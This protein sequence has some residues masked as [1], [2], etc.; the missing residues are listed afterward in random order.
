M[1]VLLV[2][3]EELI[4]E[5]MNNSNTFQ[6]DLDLENQKIDFSTSIKLI[7]VG[8]FLLIVFCAFFLIRGWF[9]LGFSVLTALFA[10]AIFNFLKR[11]LT[12]DIEINVDGLVEKNIHEGLMFDGYW[13]ENSDDE[14]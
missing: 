1:L 14:A 3:F 11:G 6:L 2:N 9:V 5:A 13:L 12:F 7:H 8:Y 4:S 10:V